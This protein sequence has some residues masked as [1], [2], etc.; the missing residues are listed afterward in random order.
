MKGRDSLWKT[1][2]R[3]NWAYNQ[4]SSGGSVPSAPPSP[5]VEVASGP[6]RIFVKWSYP[7]P[8]Y[9][10]DAVSGQDD[11]AGWRIYRK[12]G[13]LLVNDPAD[14]GTQKQWRLVFTSDDR[15]LSEW[16]DFNVVRGVDY[17]YAVTAV[18]NGVFN[19]SPIN[20]G[21]PLESSRHITRSLLPAVSFKPGL[22]VS[23]LV[24][25]VPNPAT[26][27]SGKALLAGDE[28]KISFFNLPVKCTLRIFTETGNLI[29]VIE[30]Y[31]TADHE[32]N[33]LTDTNQFVTSGIYILAVTD[34][35][36]VDGNKLDNQFVKFVIVR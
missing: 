12:E 20:P 24:R 16:E 34:C 3:A 2:D 1:L 10:L 36:D 14:Q 9:F 6:D 17:Y 18:D 31:G 22:A 29:R 11:W 27:A 25:V 21:S 15:N 7:E 5:D 4:I 30:H 23:D 32:W 33:Q 13:A 35:E 28:N 8:D 19:T 26:V